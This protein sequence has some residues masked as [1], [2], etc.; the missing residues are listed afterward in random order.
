[1]E[2]GEEEKNDVSGQEPKQ[3]LGFQGTIPAASSKTSSKQPETIKEVEEEE[4]NLSCEEVNSDDMAGGLC[5]SDSDEGGERRAVFKVM[6]AEK[7]GAKSG[8]VAAEMNGPK[9]KTYKQEFDTNVFEVKLDCLENKG[10][11]AT[12]D[13]QLC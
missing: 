2:N 13:A 12:G 3:M 11:V 5:D 4:A 1:M 10:E 9:P 8:G 7:R 6:R